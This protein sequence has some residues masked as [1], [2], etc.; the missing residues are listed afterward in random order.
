MAKAVLELIA[1]TTGWDGGINKAIGGLHNFINANGGLHKVLEQNAAT[2]DKAVAKFGNLGSKATTVQGRVKEL[3]NAYLQLGDTLNQMTRAER[4]VHGKNVIAQMKL[5]RTEVLKTRKEMDKLNGKIGIAPFGGG[6]GFGAIFKGN[7]MASVVLTTLRK[8]RDGFIDGIKTNIDFEQAN[9]TLASVLGTTTD[10]IA[11]LTENA[12]KLGATTVWTA[13]QITELQTVL[14]RRGFRDDQILEMTKGISSLATATGIELAQAAEI[15]GSTMQS[16]EMKASEMGDI[17]AS[18]GV[19]TTKSALDMEKLQYALSY[20]AGTANKAG[21]ELNEVLAIMGALADAGI[22]ASTIGMAVRN[23]IID[24]ADGSSR[25]GKAI[26]HPVHNLKEF[27]AALDD[28]KKRGY[29]DLEKIAGIVDARVTTAFSILMSNTE[30]MKSLR[31]EVTNVKDELQGMVDNQLNTAQGSITLLTSAWDGLMLSFTNSTSTIKTVTDAL[32]RLINAWTKARL[33]REGGMAAVA[34]Y[35]QEVNGQEVRSNIAQRLAS[36][37]TKKG[38]FES[39]QKNLIT[40]SKERDE[41]EQI[42]QWLGR[43]KYM[44]YTS[45]AKVNGNELWDVRAKLEEK[46]IMGVHQMSSR[47]F[48]KLYDEYAQRLGYARYKVNY[49][50][51][52]MNEVVEPT[53]RK[54]KSSNS[55]VV[56]LTEAQKNAQKRVEDALNAY[57]IAITKAALEKEAGYIN[58]EQYTQKI[59]RA[60]ETLYGVY[61]DLAAEL[62]DEEWK[63]NMQ[64]EAIRVRELAESAEKLREAREAAAEAEREEARQLRSQKMIDYRILHGLQGEAKKIGVDFDSVGLTG[65]KEKIDGETLGNSIGQD[66]WNGIVDS[67]NSMGGKLNYTLAIDFETGAIEKLKKEIFSLGDA[68]GALQN[69]SSGF[70]SLKTSTQDLAETLQGDADGFDKM[71]AVIDYGLGILQTF[72][73]IQKAIDVLSKMAIVTKQAETAATI[74]DTTASMANA[75]AKGAEASAAG[76]AAAA[77]GGKAVAGIPIAGPILAV[78]AIAAITAA[79]ASAFSKTE[80]HAGGGMVGMNGMRPLGTDVVPAMLTPGEI[81]LNHAQQSNIANQLQG[82]GRQMV[83]V[84]GESYIS[85]DQLRIV[86]NNSAKHRGV[87]GRLQ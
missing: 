39:E 55:T 64:N 60:E 3:S 7:V 48:D 10:K 68:V 54:R 27:I 56:E 69:L 78:A 20:A 83:L 21:F 30:K 11:A 24:L 45:G 58:E 61:A 73:S 12:K 84:Q 17:V 80:Y 42:F 79:I 13:G 75:A 4:K 23:I 82:A 5:I 32:T 66:V 22:P 87:A 6:S 31:D 2:F 40:L 46:G 76:A 44:Q 34:Q 72:V 37:Q 85:G 51:A 8:V 74:E 35:E 15:A 63:K 28:L 43:I 70:Q 52:L 1:N 57:E 38:I 81:V 9:A 62:G 41:L 50:S 86:Y 25:L 29:D 49:T 16:F 53:A 26:G 33:I 19:S 65:L 71:F 77:E 67:L 36:G 59:L 47:E 14:A 18:L